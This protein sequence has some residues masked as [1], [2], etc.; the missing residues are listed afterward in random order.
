[1]MIKQ[2]NYQGLRSSVAGAGL[3]L[4]M[5]AQAWAF[6]EAPM[7]ADK[8]AAGGLPPV[9][10]RMPSEPMVMETLDS[11]GEYGGTLRRAILGGG[12]QHNMLRQIGTELLVRWSHDWSEVKPNIAESWR[13]SDDA[14]TYTFK[15]REG[16]R[17]SD[18]AP[19]TADDIMFWYEIFMDET[20]TPSKH[21]NYVDAGGPVQVT[22][23]DD[24]TVEF[25]FSAPNGLFLQNMAY[26]FGYYPVVYPKHYLSQFH[27]AY[28]DDIQALIDAEPA[29]SDWVQLFNLKAG[30]MHTPL[31]W[32]NP[33]RPTLHP[34]KTTNAYGSSDRV[35]AERNP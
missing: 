30:P 10:E 18:G 9:A 8:V 35:V 12:D 19:F 17:W 14:A 33:D 16:M 20:L 34:W 26:G 7:L 1:M 5:T 25:K 27:K 29:A 11:I 13:V 2:G 21:P 4:A 22:K 3:M 28:N 31:F 6:E 24:T 32:Q 15:L 23:V